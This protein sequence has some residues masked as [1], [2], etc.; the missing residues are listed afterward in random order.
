MYVNIEFLRSRWKR[1]HQRQSLNVEPF[2]G[3]AVRGPPLHCPT[4]G[5]GE[6]PPPL[7]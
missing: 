1:R 4:G 3:R 2:G 6:S 7:P 5:N